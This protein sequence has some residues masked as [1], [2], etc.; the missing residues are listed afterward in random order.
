M[1][2]LIKTD[3]EEVLRRAAQFIRARLPEMSVANIYFAAGVIDQLESR[4]T[5]LRSI[6]PAVP[7]GKR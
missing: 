2:D 3:D 4:N 5:Q 7:A 6:V 1:N